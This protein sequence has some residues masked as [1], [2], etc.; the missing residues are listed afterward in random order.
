MSSNEKKFSDAEGAVKYDAV[1]TTGETV[2][3]EGPFKL[4]L[5]NEDGWWS[6]F[7]FV[8]PGFDW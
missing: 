1:L 6:I 4:Y 3:L 2:H 5:S 7:Y 8:F